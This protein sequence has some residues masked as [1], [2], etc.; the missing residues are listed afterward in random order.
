VRQFSCGIIALLMWVI[1][2]FSQVAVSAAPLKVRLAYPTRSMS[3]LH[4]QVAA[5]KGFFIK[6]GLDV[7][8]IQIRSA[9]SL[10]A[11]LGNE[12]QYMTSIGTGIRAAAKGLP[13][14]VVLVSR[15]SPLFFVVSRVKTIPELRGKKIG[16]TGNP[17]SS[18]E[19]VTRLVLERHGLQAGRDYA[20]VYGGDTTA[21]FAAFR[22]GVLDSISISL[23]FPIIAENEGAYVLAKSS[24]VIRMASTGL[25]VRAAALSQQRQEI[26]QMIRADIEAREFIHKNKPETVR[27]IGRWLEMDSRTAARSYDLALDSFR[28]GAM[29]KPEEIQAAVDIEGIKSEVPLERLFD[30]SLAQEIAKE[31]GR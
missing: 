29:F 21:V 2:P 6:Q 12:I 28:R 9:V 19:V 16:V 20:F 26:K 23:P 30:V 24:D 13:I 1:F 31:S 8:A 27:I 11:L 7:E 22:T 25:A 3:L 5:E 14:K 4:I 17:G 15:D 18:T 10:P